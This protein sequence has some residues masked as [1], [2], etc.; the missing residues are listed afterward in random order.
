M[1]DEQDAEAV[2]ALLGDATVRTILAAASREALSAKELGA[3]CDTSVSTV[4]RRVDELVDHEL[5]VE[6]TRIEDGGTHVSV[7][8]TAVRGF[9]V[10]L[11]D[12]A[13]AVEPNRREDAAGRFTNIWEDIRRS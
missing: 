7:Y 8:E 12:G 5:L 4:Y 3:V 2:L 9:D 11:E 13:W 1:A 6:R 10:G